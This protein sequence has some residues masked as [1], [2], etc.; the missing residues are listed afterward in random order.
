M[1]AARQEGNAATASCPQY[2][3]R[4]PTTQRELRDGKQE[5]CIDTKID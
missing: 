2:T 4:V 5:W 1:R 3:T